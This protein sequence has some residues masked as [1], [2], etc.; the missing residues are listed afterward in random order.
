VRLFHDE[1]RGSFFLAD[2]T[3]RRSSVEGPLGQP[4]RAATPPR[5][6]SC[7]LA[8]LTGEASCRRRARARRSGRDGG[9]AVGGSGMRS[10]PSTYLSA[11]KEVAIV[12]SPGRRRP[13]PRRRGHHQPLPPQPCPRRVPPRDGPREPRSRSFGTARRDRRATAHVCERFAC[14]LPV[15][16]PAALAAQVG[17]TAV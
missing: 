17:G 8:H 1:G 14:L 6:T 16:D 15:T 4:Y 2:G 9:G 5:P 10:G 3:R 12:G 11:V 7:C 13:W